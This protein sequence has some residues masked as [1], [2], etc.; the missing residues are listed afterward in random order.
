MLLTAGS[1]DELNY[2]PFHGPHDLA[3][4]LRVHRHASSRSSLRDRPRLRRRHRAAHPRASLLRLARI[5]GGRAARPDEPAPAAPAR[6]RRP[7]PSPPARRPARED[8]TSETRAPDRPGVP[9]AARRLAVR[10]G[11]GAGDAG[12][13]RPLRADPGAGSTWS[14]V[15]VDQ[16]RADVRRQRHDG[17]LH[18]RPA[19]PTAARSSSQAHRRLRG[20]RD[21]VP[22][23][24]GARPV[25][26]AA[27]ARAY[28][29]MPIVAGGTVVHVQP[30]DRRQAGH[31]PAAVRRDDREDL[32]RPDHQLERPGDHQG[33]QRASCPAS[34]SSRWCARTARA[35]T[36][37]FTTWMARQ[38]P[39]IW[40]P[41]HQDRRHLS[42]AARACRTTRRSGDP[43]VARPAPIGVAN[44]DHRVV[45]QRA[46]SPTSSTRTR[47]TTD[48]PVVKVLNKAGYYIAAD[49]V[50]RGRRADPGAINHDK[51]GQP[52]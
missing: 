34:R 6:P 11:A 18:R 19:P 24:D 33:Q 46:P 43:K 8:P 42:A 5:I 37:Q 51:I 23:P 16:W 20:H 28:A 35:T 4:A 9:P 39:S 48:F 38:Y 13:G 30:E 12:P 17:Q 15:A 52:T 2:D 1:T 41:V 49:R 47:S 32:H 40:L 21:P 7:R 22:G 31:Q 36:A 44:Y 10:R 14:Q 25:R 26:L 3:P 45:R 50:Q 29:Y 27:P